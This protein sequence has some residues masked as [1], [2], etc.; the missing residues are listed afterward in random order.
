MHVD[1]FSRRAGVELTPKLFFRYFLCVIQACLEI[2]KGI[3]SLC[4]SFSRNPRSAADWV[5]AVN[6]IAQTGIMAADLANN[7][8]QT[9]IM[10][11]Q[12]RQDYE[13]AMLQ[14]EQDRRLSA[15]NE[16]LQRELNKEIVNVMVSM[17]KRLGDIS[18]KLDQIGSH[19]RNEF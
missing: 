6:G 4:Q 14:M 5:S 10:E 13:N 1:Y 2:F 19:I 3:S 16:K 17:E 18:N 12:L 8:K 15:E 11:K 7:Y 9:E